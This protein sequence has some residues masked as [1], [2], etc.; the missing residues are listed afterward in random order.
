MDQLPD[1]LLRLARLIGQDVTLVYE[2]NFNRV[3]VQRRHGI[4]TGFV[5]IEAERKK[6][7][8]VAVTWVSHEDSSLWTTPLNDLFKVI[9]HDP[10]LEDV[11]CRHGEE[12]STDD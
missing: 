6:G 10:S 3:D 8:A 5:E 9:P 12:G 1:R 7:S 11:Q 4:I 2:L